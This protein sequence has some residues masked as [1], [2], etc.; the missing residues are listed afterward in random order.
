MDTTSEE[1][2]H[3]C[4]VRTIIRDRL[5]KGRD[6]ARG[7]LDLVEKHRGKPARARLEADIRQQWE[8]GNRGLHPEWL[9]G[10]RC[11]SPSSG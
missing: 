11:D 7:H 8:W 2:R 1:F 9:S 4:E 10:P 5:Q 6:W 3:Q